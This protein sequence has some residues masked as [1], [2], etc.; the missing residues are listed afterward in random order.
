VDRTQQPQ[1][2]RTRWQEYVISKAY[3]LDNERKRLCDQACQNSAGTSYVEAATT[4][5]LPTARQSA[6]VKADGQT[7]IRLARR[8]RLANPS[9]R[10]A[11]AGGV[12]PLHRPA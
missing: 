3:Y 2:R 6:G 8:D 10:A 1:P 11:G 4:K 12:G 5:H 9:T 7:P